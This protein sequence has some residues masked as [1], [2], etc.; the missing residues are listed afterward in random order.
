MAPRSVGVRGVSARVLSQRELGRATLARQLLLER[1]T[2]QPSAL[3]EHLVGL[4]AQEAASWYTGFWSRLDG[5]DPL[6]VSRPLEDREIVR[7]ALMRSTIHLV[8]TTDALRLR[9][10]LQPAVARPMS[11]RGRTELL[12]RGLDEIAAAGRGL[13]DAE[14]LTNARL[15]AALA[16]KWPAEERSNLV[17]AVRVAVPL[18]QVTPRGMWG[19]KG[20]AK[21]APLES[22]IGR[23]L[24][25]DYPLDTLV[26]RYLAAF[27]PA[28]PAD[29]SAWSGLSGMRDVFECMRPELFTFRAEDASCSIYP[30]P[31]GRPPRR[32]LP[33]AS[34]RTTTT[35]CSATPTGAVSSRTR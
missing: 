27:G 18:V 1:A 9:P 24:E 21:H 4:Q 16:G 19:R 25:P 7:I 23:P 34:S 29:A 13:L 17:M 15:G 3:L 28:T 35:S 30:T 2:M 10:L 33:R 26:R 20:A 14:P 22:W 11:G 12:A 32:P 31:Q 6:E 8:T 5:F